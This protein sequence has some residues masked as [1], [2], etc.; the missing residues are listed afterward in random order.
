MDSDTI[1]ADVEATDSLPGEYYLT[2]EGVGPVAVGELIS[3]L[4]SY[5]PGLYTAIEHGDTDQAQEYIFHNNGAAVMTALD[6]MEGKIDVLYLSTPGIK[7][8]TPAGDIQ[9]GDSFS[10]VLSLPGLEKEFETIDEEGSAGMWY[11]KW[12]GLWF[13]VDQSRLTP[14]LVDKLYSD[15]KEPLSV[16]FDDKVKIGYIG[17]GL[18]F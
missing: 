15:E 6:F 2:P 4:P 1:V 16:D 10:K 7:V 17:T 13:T 11:W 3:N 9:I 18:P 8:Q 5:M 14:V 12:D